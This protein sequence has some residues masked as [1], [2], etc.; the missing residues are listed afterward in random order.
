MFSHEEVAQFGW[1][2]VL[3]AVKAEAAVLDKEVSWQAYRLVNRLGKGADGRRIPK[4]VVT[5]A[6]R[7]LQEQGEP[8][9]EY[10]GGYWLYDHDRKDD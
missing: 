1:N 4:E 7:H 3:Q 2:L 8:V 9:M 10:G 6:L 5:S